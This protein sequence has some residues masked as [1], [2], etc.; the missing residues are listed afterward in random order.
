ML[1]EVQLMVKESTNYF[2]CKL[3][4][5]YQ[6]Y[7]GHSCHHI[8]LSGDRGYSC[9]TNIKL[10]ALSGTPILHSLNI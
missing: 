5:R 2:W 1:M 9:L 3:Y 10:R 6:S 4:A 8:N 7:K